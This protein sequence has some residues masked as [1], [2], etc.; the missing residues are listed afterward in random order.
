MLCKR[1]SPHMCMS[2]PKYGPLWHRSAKSTGTSPHLDMFSAPN[3]SALGH[4]L[5]QVHLPDHL[6]KSIECP[7]VV[8]GI[9]IPG[10][11]IHDRWSVDKLSIIAI[12]QTWDMTIIDKRQDGQCHVPLKIPPSSPA[13]PRTSSQGL[14]TVMTVTCQKVQ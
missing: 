12:Y 11:S 7:R 8:I 1:R 2:S 14:W 9:E 10:Q 13:P 6:P 5:C 4:K 3:Q